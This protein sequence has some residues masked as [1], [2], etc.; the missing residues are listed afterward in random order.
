MHTIHNWSTLG[1]GGG[2]NT[3][4]DKSFFCWL[5]CNNNMHVV[6]SSIEDCHFFCYLQFGS[7]L[8]FCVDFKR[9]LSRLWRFFLTSFKI[10]KNTFQNLFVKY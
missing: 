3:A 5:T 9:R 2:T 10:F 4:G 7:F 6:K 1:E 8:P